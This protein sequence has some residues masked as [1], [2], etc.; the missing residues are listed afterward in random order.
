[1]ATAAIRWGPSFMTTWFDLIGAGSLGLVNAT[2]G[3]DP[4]RGHTFEHYARRSIRNECIRSAKS[5]LSSVDRPFYIDPQLPGLVT[6]YCG[7]RA[8][9]TRI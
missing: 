1:M 9:P 2:D 4:K 8:R 7:S 6:D 5:L 3:F